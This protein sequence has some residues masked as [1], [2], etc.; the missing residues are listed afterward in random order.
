MPSKVP[1]ALSVPD[2]P[3]DDFAS[4]SSVLTLAPFTSR[5]AV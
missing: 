5:F 2:T 4:A 3:A 1:F